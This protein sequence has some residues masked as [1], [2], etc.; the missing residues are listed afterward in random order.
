[1]I[2]ETVGPFSVTEEAVVMK[3]KLTH[4]YGQSGL[5]HPIIYE[6]VSTK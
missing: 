4:W 1:M 3:L 5:S 2:C 6:K